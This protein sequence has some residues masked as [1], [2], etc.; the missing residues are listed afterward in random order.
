MPKAW[1][2]V[3][4]KKRRR[5][6]RRAKPCSKWRRDSC[7]RAEDDM[8]KRLIQNV[9][10]AIPASDGAG[11]KLM[12]SL[13]QGPLARLDPFLMLDMFSSEEASDYIAGFPP[14]PH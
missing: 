11:V 3:P 6:P 13:G 7:L 14:H 4:R 9:I 12:R 5:W 2:S 8:T 10:R 1:R